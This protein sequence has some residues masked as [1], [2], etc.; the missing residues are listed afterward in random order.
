M[1]LGAPDAGKGAGGAVAQASRQ[2]KQVV[3]EVAVVEEPG[4]PGKA[5]V[6]PQRQR[7]AEPLAVRADERFGCGEVL[8]RRT[9]SG[10][11]A[12]FQVASL[13]GT[14]SRSGWLSGLAN[15]VC[16]GQAVTAATA[17]AGGATSPGIRRMSRARWRSRVPAAGGSA[18]AVPPGRHARIV[19]TGSLSAPVGRQPRYGFAQGR[20]VIFR[21][22]GR[23]PDPRP[24]AS[25][26]PTC[27]PAKWSTLSRAP[28]GPDEKSLKIK[29]M[30]AS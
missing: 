15:D 7:S 4:G 13:G 26:Q 28:A 18:A 12:L 8:S 19:S 22:D 16:A 6:Q 29:P 14:G 25:S 30:P 10:S 21:T 11:P 20:K 24:T 27:S 3:V 9:W 2:R 1:L 23:L 17:P 5:D